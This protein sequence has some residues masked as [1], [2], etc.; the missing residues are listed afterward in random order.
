MVIS[1]YTVSKESR[2]P[3]SEDTPNT[4]N[5][6]DLAECLGV[7]TVKFGVN[8]TTALDQVQWS[9]GSVSNTLYVNHM[10]SD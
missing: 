3:A 6:S 5:S 8:L 9:N 7:T 2:T 10:V 4:L 1:A